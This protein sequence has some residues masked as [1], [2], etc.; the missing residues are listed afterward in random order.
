MVHRASLPADSEAQAGCWSGLLGF[1]KQGKKPSTSPNGIP[2]LRCRLEDEASPLVRGGSF[3]HPC[4]WLP[5]R[6]LTRQPS[7]VHFAH[8]WYGCY[9]A[10][11][12]LPAKH[13]SDTLPAYVEKEGVMSEVAETVQEKLKEL[14]PE[15]RKLSMDL[16]RALLARLYPPVN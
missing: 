1:R 15:L 13:S 9:D 12:P 7:Y 14:S 11:S 16:W 5:H 4:T 6:A 3:L 8:D 2:T 10:P